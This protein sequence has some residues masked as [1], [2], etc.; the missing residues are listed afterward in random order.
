[1]VHDTPVTNNIVAQYWE[2]INLI[3]HTI[4]DFFSIIGN[5]VIIKSGINAE[6]K[7]HTK[8]K[9]H[10]K[11]NIKI[12]NIKRLWHL[13]QIVIGAILCIMKT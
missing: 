5:I 8:S 1:M 4:Y 2:W 13:Y 12:L 6:Y 7:E 9:R 10:E 11:L 3:W